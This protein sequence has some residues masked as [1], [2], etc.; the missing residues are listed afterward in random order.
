[1]R[2]IGLQPSAQVCPASGDSLW[3]V[4]RAKFAAHSGFLAEA[5]LEAV[6]QCVLQTAHIMWTGATRHP[7]ATLPWTR[8]LDTSLGRALGDYSPLAITS[9]FLS[10]IVIVT[11]GFVHAHPHSSPHILL[12][13]TSAALS[14]ALSA[15][16][17]PHLLCTSASSFG[18][19][20]PHLGHPSAAALQQ[21][22]PLLPSTFRVPSEYLPS[23]FPQVGRL[24]LPISPHISPYLPISPAGGSSPSPH[25]SPYLPISPAGGSSPSPFTARLSPSTRSAWRATSSASS[26]PSAG[27]SRATQAVEIWARYGADMGEIW[28]D[29]DLLA[30]RRQLKPFLE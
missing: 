24:F 3:L 21:P 5:V 9:I 11:K 14:A 15:T 7:P 10:V 23:T 1:M 2:A 22:C 30:R 28:G 17:R 6:P 13:R 29:M 27:S 18:R 26:P 20:A 8:P 25:I 12:A 19:T 4:F 16:P